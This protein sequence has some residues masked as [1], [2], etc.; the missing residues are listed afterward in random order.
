MTQQN[1]RVF[2]MQLAAGAA[3]LGATQAHAQAKPLDEAD[4]LAAAQG[5]KADTTKVDAKKYPKHS[6]EQKCGNCALFQGKAGDAAGPCPL[7]AGKTVSA[8]GWCQ[9]YAKKA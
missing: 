3:V 6:K 5:Y 7:F 4:P 2:M 8:N 1:R 9:A